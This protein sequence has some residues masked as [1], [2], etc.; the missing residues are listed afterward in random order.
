MSSSPGRARVSNWD[1]CYDV[2]PPLFGTYLPWWLLSIGK[3]QCDAPHTIIRRACNDR[4]DATKMLGGR[5]WIMITM[6]WL[7]VLRQAVVF[8]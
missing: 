5:R 6:V 3:K 2:V 1:A 4:N 7:A 8:S